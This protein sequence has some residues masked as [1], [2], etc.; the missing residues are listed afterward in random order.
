MLTCI[1]FQVKTVYHLNFLSRVQVD[2]LEKDLEG[3][4]AFLLDN[5]VKT[6]RDFGKYIRIPTTGQ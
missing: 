1:V 3:H 6:I 5:M 4:M 2:K